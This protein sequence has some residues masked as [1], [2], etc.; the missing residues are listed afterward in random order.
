MTWNEMWENWYKDEQM[1]RLVVVKLFLEAYVKGDAALM[2][3]HAAGLAKVASRRW[4]LVG[5]ISRAV[6]PSYDD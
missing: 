4:K 2:W 5:M 6:E 1:E 3:I